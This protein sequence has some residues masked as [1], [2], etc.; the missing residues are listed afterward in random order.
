MPER[1]GP[2]R[3]ARPGWRAPGAR[4]WRRRR[5]LGIA[6]VRVTATQA[7]PVADRSSTGVTSTR[8]R[9]PTRSMTAIAIA[10]PTSTS[11]PTAAARRP[12]PVD[13]GDR[14]MSARGHV[15]PPRGGPW[16][17]ANASTA[18]F[19]RV[20]EVLGVDG[21]GQ[22]VARGPSPAPASSS[23]RTRGR[24]P[25]AFSSTS[26][27]S[28]MSAAVVSMSVIGS[29]ATTIHV[30]RGSEAAIRRISSR[31]VRALAKSSGASNRKR[32][33]PVDGLALG[34][35]SAVVEAR[36]PVHSTELD[37][38]RHP[39]LAGTRSGSR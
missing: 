16:R 31:N 21:P 9:S 13:R 30:G 11:A 8:P 26:R 10:A 6:P 7:R 24:S 25:R 4:R 2:P 18:C 20:E 29:A 1:R 35:D 27:S 33:R 12:A 19:D 14:S 37:P 15:A 39:H 23:P 36:Q 34:M 5:R 17:A 22:L 3:S 38:I 28:S 32:T